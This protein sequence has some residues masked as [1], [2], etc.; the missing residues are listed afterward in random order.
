M[1]LEGG[2]HGPNVL[3]RSDDEFTYP[4][5]GS[6]MP[7]L[8]LLVMANRCLRVAIF[9]HTSS[10]G[11]RNANTQTDSDTDDEK[12]DKDLGQN[13]L[14]LAEVPHWVPAALVLTAEALLL[15]CAQP[16]RGFL[17]VSRYIG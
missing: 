5:V 9:P 2:P 13:L 8:V 17:V 4:K 10:S 12:S 3:E 11:L 14:S 6:R 16:R 15:R 1:T 7:S